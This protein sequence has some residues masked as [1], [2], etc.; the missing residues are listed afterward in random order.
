MPPLSQFE[1]LSGEIKKL[2]IRFETGIKSVQ[3]FVRFPDGTPVTDAE[4][5]AYSSANNQWVSGYPDQAGNYSFKVGPGAWKIGIRPKDSSLAKWTWLENLPEVMFASD[6]STET[7]TANFTVSPLGAKL[8]IQALDA[9]G[10]A[11]EGAGIVADVIPSNQSSAVSSPEFRKTDQSGSASFLLAGG[12]YYIRAFIDPSRGYI[13]P[14]EESV[15]LLAG[16]VKNLKLV[17]KK[18]DLVEAVDVLGTAKLDTGVVTSASV[19]AWSDKGR[20]A[21]GKADNAGNFILRISRGDVWHIGAG[22]ESDG[23]AYKSSD[24]IASTYA[25]VGRQRIRQRFLFH[26]VQRQ[27]AAPL[28]SGS[29]RQSKLRRRRLPILLVPRMMLQ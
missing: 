15:N 23:I 17:F 16:G 1:V 11:L 19:W 9:S 2:T 26:P 4:V 14:E 25:V 6:Q 21:E 5:G 24:F 20:F 22:K 10:V 7:K 3:G 12:R 13:N 18:R 28:K 27:P 29:I 8:I